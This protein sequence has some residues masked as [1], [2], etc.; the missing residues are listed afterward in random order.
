MIIAKAICLFVELEYW[1]IRLLALPINLFYNDGR[2]DARGSNTLLMRIK[3]MRYFTK[4]ECTVGFFALLA[5]LITSPAVAE[6]KLPAVVG[7][8]MVL[9]QSR[10]VPL[11]GWTQP[12]NEV[13][14]SIAGQT[15]KAKPDDKGRWQ[16]E[17]APMKAGG[18]FELV[19][20]D[21]SG[22]KKTI[23]D[24]MVGEVWVCSG[25][26]NME[27]SLS[28]ANNSQEEIKNAN[29]PKLR[30]FKV[31]KAVADTPQDNCT[32]DW[33]VC[34]PD[35]IGPRSAVGYFFGQELLKELKVPIGLLQTSVG[36]T[37]AEAWTSRKALESKPILRPIL[38]VWDAK[39]A[40][41]AD[42]KNN[43]RRPA[44]L[45]NAM[46]APLIPYAI[47]GA[48]WYQGEGNVNQ[49]Y[50]YRT[51]F[52]VMIENWREKWGQ[53]QFPFGFVQLA[54]YNYHRKGRPPECCPELWEAQ[55]LTLKKV[56]N[57]GMAVTMDIGDVKDIHP[58][59]KQDVGRR[60]A[61]WALARTYDKSDL[62][63][64]G[65]I[66]ESM[67]IEGHKIRLRFDHVDGGLAT[68]DGKPPSDFT[69]AGADKKFHPAKAKIDGDTIVVHSP[70][71]ADPV[72]ARYAWRDDAGPNLTNK[73]G[74]PASPFR[75]DK[76]KGVTQ[77]NRRPRMK[78]R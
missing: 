43:K 53:G 78:K 14:V 28:R 8:H 59:N 68:S 39:V 2:Q 15:V 57:T 4:L 47:R 22:D 40:K 7:D 61:L 33:I 10:P 21:A 12:G 52:P 16:V 37:P 1:W 26:S 50:Q 58:K 34:K 63:Y 24:V 23:H 45:Y 64:S 69:I 3:M 38:K 35:S 48:I 76:W 5:A 31:Q 25:Q 77:G 70:A 55:L 18:P 42:E 19:V 30:L 72:A 11:W 41:S 9:Q 36:G 13:T 27:F 74:L 56:P 66:Y 71:V 51:L 60:L 20:S 17:L 65:P 54:P 6:L 46:V 75:T 73:S 32:G 49:A 44:N 67:G 29:Y 62:V